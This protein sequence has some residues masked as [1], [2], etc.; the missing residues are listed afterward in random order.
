MRTDSPAIS[1][2]ER[3]PATGLLGAWTRFWFTPT[4]PVGLHWLRVLSGLLFL[5]WLLPLTGERAALFGLNGWFDKAAHLEA[6][7]LQGG[8]PVPIGWSLLYTE[9]NAAAVEVI[10]WLSIAVLVLFTLGVATRITGVLTWLV[11]VSFL[12]SPVSQADTDY[13]LPILALYLA[14]GYLLL[15]FWHRRLSIVERILGPRQGGVLA[16]LG[17]RDDQATP[18]YAAHL[19]IRLM[20]VHF[21][22]IV[23][24]SGLHKLQ[25]GDWW[26]GAAYWYPLHPALEMT[27]AK[28]R[29]EQPA[30]NFILFC[31]SVASYVA[32]AWQL[33]FPVFA[34]RRRFRPL[35]LVGAASAFLGA[36]FMFS[37]LTF[38]PA[39]AIFCLSYLSADEWQWLTDHLVRPL[40]RRSADEP[41]PPVER[42][43]RLKATTSRP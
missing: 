29:A 13:V 41:A 18:S 32:I 4:S 1:V 8:P 30:A 34:F 9:P 17:S 20:Q 37:E 28:L 16:M 26:R 14:I 2:E 21:A 43:S 38:G 19:A 15:G 11:V 10:W 3:A 7:R 23:V 24:S 27:A 39:Y 12:A 40:V 25:L 35:L 5:S 6:S 36:V 42:K 22:I 33:A 31:L